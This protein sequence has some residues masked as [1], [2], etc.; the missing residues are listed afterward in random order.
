MKKIIFFE[1]RRDFFEL[2]IQLAN[3]LHISY[4]AQEIERETNI[5]PLL[6][7]F[8]F[9][10]ERVY[11]IIPSTFDESKDYYSILEQDSNEA[12][13][14]K[15]NFMLDTI[16]YNAPILI[17]YPMNK[18]VFDALKILS[19]NQLYSNLFTSEFELLA[20]GQEISFFNNL[21]EFKGTINN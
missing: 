20:D 11:N 13:L 7:A 10:K 8:Y 4:I 9:N 2:Y 17:D 15:F 19:Y 16:K 18:T 1:I 21:S 12:L 6:Q 3:P 5:P 14:V